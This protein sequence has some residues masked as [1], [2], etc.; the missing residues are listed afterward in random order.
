VQM[1]RGGIQLTWMLP[2]YLAIIRLT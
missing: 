2:K 1:T